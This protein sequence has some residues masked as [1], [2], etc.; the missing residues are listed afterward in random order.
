MGWLKRIDAKKP[1]FSNFLNPI[2]HLSISN[3]NAKRTCLVDRGVYSPEEIASWTR[4][5][6]GYTEENVKI[7]V[8]VPLLIALG[9]KIIQLDFEHNEID[10][11]LRDLPPECQVIVETKKFREKLQDYLP[12]LKRYS[13]QTNALF[14]VI[15]NS[16]EIRVYAFPYDIPICIIQR[17]E[18]AEPSKY[19]LLKKLISRENLTTKNSLKYLLEE[20]QKKHEIESQRLYALRDTLEALEKRIHS[21]NFDEETKILISKAKKMGLLPLNNKKFDEGKA[22]DENL[23]KLLEKI[24]NILKKA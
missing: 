6:I 15:T 2:K 13:E 22:H 12:Q 11:F 5:D 20:I 21:L 17:K 24:E 16:E 9:H 7:K 8:A 18:L 23:S 19:Q 1:M 10:I 4:K 3:L 14:A